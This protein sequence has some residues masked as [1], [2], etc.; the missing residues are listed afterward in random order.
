MPLVY[1][2]I[3]IILSC[4]V[5]CLFYPYPAHLSK[6]TNSSLFLSVSYASHSINKNS[7]IFFTPLT[8]TKT[9][10][11]IPT[12]NM[13]TPSLFRISHVFNPIHFT[14]MDVLELLSSVSYEHL[15]ELTLFPI[16]PLPL[17]SFPHYNS[18]LAP[19]LALR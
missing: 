14:I 9:H 3:P 10:F 6:L 4:G 15:K 5:T 1:R 12:F 16:L 8:N 19:H 17:L 18:Y 13:S 7:P 2:I 11:F